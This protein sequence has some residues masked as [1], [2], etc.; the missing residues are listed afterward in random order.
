MSPKSD[1]NHLSNVDD[2]GTLNSDFLTA[3]R[4][5]HHFQEKGF[6]SNFIWMRQLR[7]GEDQLVCLRRLE[8]ELLSFL[9]CFSFSTR[10]QMEKNT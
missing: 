10:L 1:P 9:L 5:V 4:I 6:E 3:K 2:K 8:I 7:F